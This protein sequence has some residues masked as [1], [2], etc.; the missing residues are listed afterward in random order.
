MRDVRSVL[1]LYEAVKS[2]DPSSP[3]GELD[4]PLL[5]LCEIYMRFRVNC[6]RV[7]AILSKRGRSGQHSAIGEVELRQFITVAQVR[8]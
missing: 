7:E 8:K 1:E 5:T 6:D 2:D 4:N 3:E